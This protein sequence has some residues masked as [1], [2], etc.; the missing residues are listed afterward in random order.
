MCLRYEEDTREEAGHEL[1]QRIG[2]LSCRE[3]PKHRAAAEACLSGS[4]ASHLRPDILDI[5]PDMP[6]DILTKKV[7]G[8]CAEVPSEAQALKACG[9]GLVQGSTI[10]SGVECLRNSSHPLLKV[11]ICSSSSRLPGNPQ[12]S[13][14][15]S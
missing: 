6:Y 10:R 4:A 15:H 1:L 2:L 5:H 14:C 9:P 12:S 13:D 8:S 11:T 7:S 3:L